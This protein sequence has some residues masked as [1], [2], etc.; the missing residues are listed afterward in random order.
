MD[1]MT[2]LVTPRNIL[3][4]KVGSGG[5]SEA[6]LKKAQT[7]I[8]E[9]D[10]D[11]VPL[12]TKY[13]GL[14]KVAIAKYGETKDSKM[15]YGELLDQLT[16]LRAQGSMFNYPS[17]TLITDVVVDLLESLNK[18]DNK[19]IEIVLAHEKASKAILYSKIK[20]V[21][22]PVCRALAKELTIVCKKYKLK[23]SSV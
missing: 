15:L 14:V 19:I 6:S 13:L 20:N 5:F 3:K 18:I 22:H 8:D 1:S 7:A 16:Q 10:V 2:R 21:D 9:N 4:E 23:Y 12:A 17:I 11:F